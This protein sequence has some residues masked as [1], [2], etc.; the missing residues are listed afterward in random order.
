MSIYSELLA[1]LC[2]DVDPLPLP[3]SR[4]E[5]VVIL[6]QCR[7]RVAGHGDEGEHIMAEDLALELDH[8][9]MLL[10]LCTAMGIESEPGRF[11]N[12]LVE[13]ERLEAQLREVG[14]DF[15]TLDD[16]RREKVA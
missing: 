3:V 12:P 1:G 9:R 13:R 6:L 5:L 2:A 7:R 11:G 8:D 15:R 10:R 4:D 14:V 16:N